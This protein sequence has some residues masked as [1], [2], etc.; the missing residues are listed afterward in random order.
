MMKN[1]VLFLFLFS[2]I[3]IYPVGEWQYSI[4]NHERHNY[5][6]G[7][8]NWDIEQG[9]NNWIYFANSKGLLE[10][11]GVYWNSY[12]VPYAM[13]RSICTIGD[14]IYI[15]GSSEFGYFEKDKNNN[16][17]YKSLSNR[18]NIL[19]GEVWNIIEYKH[20][21]YF[22]SNNSIEKYNT[23]NDTLE[24]IIIEGTIYKSLLINDK[25]IFG[26]DL[27]VLEYSLSDGSSVLIK[28]L[29]SLHQQKI[30]SILAYKEGILFVT[31]NEG[32]FYYDNKKIKKLDNL[33]IKSANFINN[34][35]LFCAAI[36]GSILVLGSIH[37]GAYLFDLEDPSISAYFNIDTGLKNNTILSLL[38]DKQENLWL[39]LDKGIAYVNLQ[40]S[41]RPLF[42]NISLI[43]SGYC[44]ARYQQKLYLG[45]NQGLFYVDE[46]QNLQSV[47]DMKGQIW[48][49]NVINGT[50]FC[51]G[52]FGIYI[53]DKQQTYKLKLW[54]SWEVQALKQYNDTLLVATYF[55]FNVLRKERGRWVL[56]DKI[57][58]YFNSSKGFVEDEQA[59]HI[60]VVDHSKC[61][62]K[63]ILDTELK[64]IVGHK[65]YILGNG[66]NISNSMIR[67]LNK[68]IIVCSNERIYKYSRLTDSFEPYNQLENLMD[69]AGYYE[70]LFID[71]LSNIWYVRSGALKLL[72]FVD[73]AYKKKNLNLNLKNELIPFYENINLLDSSNAI[74]AVDNGFFKLNIQH[75]VIASNPNVPF[76]RKVK[77][78]D[79]DSILYLGVDTTG[80]HSF[81]H[82]QNSL[83][84]EF[85]V[86]DY[87]AKSP[88]QYVC[89]LLGL[90][91]SAWGQPSEH[92]FK[93]YSNLPAGTYRFEVK[94]FVTLSEN[95]DEVVAGFSFKILPPWYKTPIALLFYLV[96]F[97][98]LIYYTTIRTIN[99]QKRII[100]EKQKE[101]KGQS[102]IYEKEQ[103]AKDR[104]INKLQTDNLKKELLLKT[105]E[106]TGYV[107]NLN[108]KNEIFED[109]KADASLV[110]KTLNVDTNVEYAKK[111][112]LLLM[113]KIDNNLER[114]SDFEVFKENFD[115]VHNDFIKQLEN[116]YPQLSHNEKV[117]CAYLRMNL[118]SKEIASL[119]NISLRGV[120]VNR[121]RL[122][123]KLNLDRTVNLNEFLQNPEMFGVDGMI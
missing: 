67:K 38:F 121:Y 20:Y 105:H 36:H 41:L 114:D 95:K 91:D 32:L 101:L 8:Q 88:K 47:D 33:S 44:S 82:K 15:G 92:T 5:N 122:R 63:Y 65:E 24:H 68:D 4:T 71:E 29:Y 18:V 79:N 27:G 76:I 73:G 116:K 23:Q 7:S 13:V 93:E 10:F 75:N 51:A 53:V 34:N 1:I 117:L 39:G 77:S 55:G 12:Q 98:L 48:S 61:I 49:L 104:E 83:K 50:L 119:Q 81:T 72:S 59:N 60:W 21:I 25:F 26:T 80:E 14:R 120:E 11:D 107:L 96:L 3:N 56:S 87:V 45:T 106:L 90:Q 111:Q 112:L 110:I 16:L 100:A 37:N 30:V 57:D 19:V 40:S 58:D 31:S 108:R 2:Y 42:S 113:E 109:I 69:G 9:T 94:E 123:K 118:S 84:F 46:N 78:I 43:G 70:H 74:V 89:R 28:S 115:L 85:G 62:Q 35:Q 99:Q 64:H 6:L 22:I 102:F 52:D 97:V 17:I 86:T 103:K 54:G 66:D